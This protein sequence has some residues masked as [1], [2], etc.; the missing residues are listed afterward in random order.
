MESCGSV[1]AQGCRPKPGGSCPWMYLDSCVLVALGRS[2]G[3]EVVVL[4]VLTVVLA[5]LGDQ[6]FFPA[7]FEYEA[8]WHRI[9]SGCF[10][11]ILICL[12]QHNIWTSAQHS[13]F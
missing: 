2:L 4:P 8:L 5:L 9:S 12:R 11:H 13:C 1:L 10:L 7:V 3:T 6:F